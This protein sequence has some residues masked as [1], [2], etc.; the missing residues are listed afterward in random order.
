[1]VEGGSF[2]LFEGKIALK[3][4]FGG[5]FGIDGIPRLVRLWKY[6]WFVGS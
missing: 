1:M 5:Y 6:H 4:K 3:G 2:W